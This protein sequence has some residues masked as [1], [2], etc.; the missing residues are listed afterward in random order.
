MVNILSIRMLLL[1]LGYLLCS[2]EINGDKIVTVSI[3]ASKEKWTISKYLASTH[4]T[5]T[6]AA[7]SIYN[8][9]LVNWYNKNNIRSTRYPGGDPCGDLEL[10]IPLWQNGLLYFRSPMEW[11]TNG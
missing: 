3:D 1:L 10:G 8:D 7:D 6:N 9:T 5:Y 4:I 11:E 2:G